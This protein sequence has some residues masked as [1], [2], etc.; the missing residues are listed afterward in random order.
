MREIQFSA[1]LLFATLR[2]SLWNKTSR[3]GQIRCSTMPWTRI[4]QDWHTYV[5]NTC[6]VLRWNS[7][8]ST[9]RLHVHSVGHVVKTFKKT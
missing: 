6:T 5:G 9:C 1:L 7:M 3:M 8:R 4:V 2:V